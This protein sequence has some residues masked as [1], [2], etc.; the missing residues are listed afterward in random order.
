M[1]YEQSIVEIENRSLL[2][3]IS[4]GAV[5]ILASCEVK[6]SET[7][8]EKSESCPVLMTASLWVACQ[9][10]LSEAKHFLD[11]HVL[12][13]MLFHTFANSLQSFHNF[14][15]IA[16]VLRSESADLLLNDGKAFIETGLKIAK[17]DF[18]VVITDKSA[19]LLAR[20]FTLHFKVSGI[21][22]LVMAA[23]SL[24][25]FLWAS[26]L[27]SLVLASRQSTSSSIIIIR[28]M[29]SQCLL[30]KLLFVELLFW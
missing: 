9:F 24:L 18:T 22:V 1:W 2:F 21:V 30:C 20:A 4:L 27:E 28:I 25:F 23:R 29:S 5:S 10:K 19:N 8:R 3:Q 7:A 12:K 6:S 15:R 17:I 13:S 11:G 26:L 14:L 16:V